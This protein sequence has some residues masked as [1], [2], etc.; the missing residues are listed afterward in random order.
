MTRTKSLAFTALFVALVAIG[1]FIRIPTPLVPITLQFAFCLA[2]AQTIGVKGGNAVA[3]YLLMGLIG[4]P[5][6]TEGGGFTYVLKPSFG[7]LIGMVTGTY[8]CGLIV[9]YK[10]DKIL[11]RLLG[12][13]AALVIVDSFGATY[14]YLLYRYYLGETVGTWE[15]LVSAVAI[16]LPTDVLWAC[17]SAT[18]GYKLRKHTFTLPTNPTNR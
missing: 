1:A 6:F 17:L 11:F 18:L 16:F 3:I 4:L 8:I 9:K 7:Y 5:V 13:F 2:A 10:G 14:M 12:S 15:F